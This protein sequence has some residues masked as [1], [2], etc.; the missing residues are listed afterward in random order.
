LKDVRLCLAAART[1]GVPLG[2]GA[3]VSQLLERTVSAL[4]AD[5]DFTAM[6]KMVESDAGLD[7]ERPAT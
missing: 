6:A 7:P 2:I 5:S 4:G 1:L 3:A